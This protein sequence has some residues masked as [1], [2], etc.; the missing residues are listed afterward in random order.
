MDSLWE[1]YEDDN[2]NKTSRN[3]KKKTNVKN[4]KAKNEFKYFDDGVSEDGDED[5]EFM[6]NGQLCCFKALKM[7]TGK[8]NLGMGKPN[9]VKIS[10]A[11]KGF[12]WLHHRHAKNVD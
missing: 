2:T 11:L 12:G 1:A 7:S 9:L 6:G 3:N 8:M 4:N 10:K 5:D